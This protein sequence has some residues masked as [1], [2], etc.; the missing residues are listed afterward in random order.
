MTDLFKIYKTRIWMSAI[1]PASFVSPTTNL[2]FSAG[3]P[4]T[5]APDQDHFHENRLKIDNRFSALSLSELSQGIFDYNWNASQP[6]SLPS[7]TNPQSYG[8]F[9]SPHAHS[10]HL[11]DIHTPEYGRGVFP[12]LRSQ[13][14]FGLQSYNVGI[15][16]R[17]SPHSGSDHKDDLASTSFSDHMKA[18]QS[19][20][21]GT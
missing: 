6:G 11:P 19:L 20:S 7:S 10:I 4:G 13:S 16:A 9:F 5:S 12:S 8:S 18:V 17:K 15:R 3:L 2:Q 1:N 14:P 21:L